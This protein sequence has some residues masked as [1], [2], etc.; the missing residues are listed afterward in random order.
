MTL[1]KQFIHNFGKWSVAEACN[2]EDLPFISDI[3]RLL[4][5]ADV[6][7]SDGINPSVTSPPKSMYFEG[8]IR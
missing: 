3:K 5:K 7:V 8:E 4:D 6:E 1:F 2:V